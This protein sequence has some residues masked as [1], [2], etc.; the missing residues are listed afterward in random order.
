MPTLACRICGRVVYTTADVENLFAEESRCPRCGGPLWMER[1]T[2]SRRKFERRQNPAAD[3]GPPSGV[4]R[5][6]SDRRVHKRRREDGKSF[7]L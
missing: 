6:G 3:P 1:R 7:G 4:E 5:R 2:A